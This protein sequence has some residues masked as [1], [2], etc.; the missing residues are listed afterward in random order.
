MDCSSPSSSIH[1]TLQAKIL[2]C[3]AKDLADL[4]IESVSLS[5]PALAD[6]F[7]ITGAAWKPQDLLSRINNIKITAIITLG[8]EV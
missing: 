3:V 1:G 7:F 8:Q 2:E 5:S 6:G 4:R